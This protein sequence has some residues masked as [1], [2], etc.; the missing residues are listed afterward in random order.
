MFFPIHYQ[1]LP[2]NNQNIF[3]KQTMSF[4]FH[5]FKVIL[6]NFGWTL[7]DCKNRGEDKLMYYTFTVTVH[8]KFKLIRFIL[9]G[10]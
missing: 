2:Y 3:L 10:I 8:V 4:M 1:L 5:P 7:S 6:H 9:F